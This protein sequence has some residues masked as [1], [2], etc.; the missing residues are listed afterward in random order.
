MFYV[1]MERMHASFLCGLPPSIRAI[2]EMNSFQERETRGNQKHKRVGAALAQ[3]RSCTAQHAPYT[4]ATG[5]PLSVTL[6]TSVRAPI[7][8]SHVWHTAPGATALEVFLHNNR[9]NSVVSQCRKGSL[10]TA[11]MLLQAIG[12]PG[13]AAGTCLR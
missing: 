8:I 12:C 4:H 10:E 9:G 13:R 3:M 5:Q 1:S 6:I 7:S 11:A 2:R